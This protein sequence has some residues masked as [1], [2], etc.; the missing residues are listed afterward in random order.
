M[1]VVDVASFVGH[2]SGN[3]MITIPKKLRDE[4]G[5]GKDTPI[6][7]E[8]VD[9]ELRVRKAAWVDDAVLVRLQKKYGLDARPLPAVLGQLRKARSETYAE[10]V[11]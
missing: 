7:F 11:G 6:V 10:E 8:V 1:G 4:L 5:I 9:G 3:G 2:I